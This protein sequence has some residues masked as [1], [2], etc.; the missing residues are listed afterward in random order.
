MRAAAAY[1]FA[2]CAAAVAPLRDRRA[3]EK[4]PYVRASLVLALGLRDPAG[5]AQTLAGAVMDA[6]A[7]VRAAAALALARN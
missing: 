5:S 3:A 1:A 4:E 6:A 7:A 2:Q